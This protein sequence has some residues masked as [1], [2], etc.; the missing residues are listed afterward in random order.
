MLRFPADL[1]KELDVA[2]IFLRVGPRDQ[3]IEAE[4]LL[5]PPL[6]KYLK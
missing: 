3:E 5:H 2:M 1:L 6:D 4:T